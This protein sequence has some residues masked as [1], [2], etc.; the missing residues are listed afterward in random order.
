MNKLQKVIYIAKL[1]CQQKQYKHI[2][3]IYETGNSKTLFIGFA[4]FSTKGNP[5][6]YNYVKTLKEL[7]A[8]KLFILDNY[9]YNHAGSYYLGEY[10]NWFMIQDIIELIH[11][12][13]KNNSIEQLVT[14]G[15]S[16]GG[17]AALY[18]GLQIHAQAA[19]CGVPQYHIGDYLNVPHHLD[20]LQ[21]IQGNKT[22]D[23]IKE[24]NELLPNAIQ[25][26]DKQLKVY[27]HFSP[28][29]HTYEDHIK[30][31]ISDLIENEYQVIID[32]NYTYTEHGDVALFFPNYLYKMCK[33]IN[34]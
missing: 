7:D 24:L 23:S 15:S 16:K 30:D 20:I 25:E 18:Y 19:I 33:K 32:K 29:E 11:F 31:M 12:I 6:R 8:H 28:C 9:G 21:G 26:G 5:P 27:L 10:G 22:K 2:K 34:A 14:F 4:G 3:Y 17:T 13:A 1:K